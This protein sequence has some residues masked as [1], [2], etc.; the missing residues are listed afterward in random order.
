MQQPISQQVYKTRGQVQREHAQRQ[1]QKALHEAPG[2]AGKSR[3]GADPPRCIGWRESLLH[4]SLVRTRG[5][6]LAKLVGLVLQ[7]L[8]PTADHWTN[9]TIVL[10]W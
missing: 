4:L 6:G 1:K 7:L 9:W 2:L 10:A 3:P 5:F 8:L